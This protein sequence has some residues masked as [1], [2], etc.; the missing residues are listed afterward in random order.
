MT[1]ETMP[2]FLE[3]EPG[4]P[5]PVDALD[6]MTRN[7]R[8]ELEDLPGKVHF[9]LVSVGPAP[10]GTKALDWVQVGRIAGEVTIL[11]LP[12][13]VQMVQEW[14][15]RSGAGK[16]K[17]SSMVDGR[18]YIIECSAKTLSPEQVKKL[19]NQLTGAE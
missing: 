17:I 4:D 12:K 2:L 3:I 16:V 18:T 19:L 13:I 8:S 6:E 11:L 9:E 7:L 5:L 14:C 1:A 15:G 10:A